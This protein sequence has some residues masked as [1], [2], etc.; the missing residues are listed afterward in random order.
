MKALIRS[1][2]ATLLTAGMASVSALALNPSHY[3][4]KSALSS[5]KWVKVRVSA[6]GVHQ[7]GYDELRQMGFSDPSKVKVCGFGGTYYYKHQFGAETPDDVN[8]TP[9]VH[10]ADG[11]L[12]FYA[13]GEYR[14]V[15]SN[16]PNVTANDTT[17]VHT[18][19][20]QHNV[21]DRYGY[22]FLTDAD[23]DV[24]RDAI[25][26]TGFKGDALTSHLSVQK[27]ERNLANKMQGG[28]AFHDVQM[29]GGSTME[30][31]MTIKN[32]A[33][34]V[35]GQ[36]GSFLA[37]VAVGESTKF[38][39]YS[40]DLQLPDTITLVASTPCY[41]SSLSS[42]DFVYTMANGGRLFDNAKAPIADGQYTFKLNF[43]TAYRLSYA[44][45][46][47]AFLVYPRTNSLDGA[48]GG[49]VMQY[50]E[51]KE[52]TPVVVSGATADTH[53]F[54]ISDAANVYE[55]KGAYDKD[56]LTYT[57]ALP[58]NYMSSSDGSG[59]GRFVA[60]NAADTHPGV[61]LVGEVAN[62][63]IHA[64][65]VPDMMVITTDELLPAARAMAAMRQA[66]DGL[67][68]A[69]YTQQQ[70]FN[71]FTSGTPHLNAYRLAA[72]MFWDRDP[73]RFKYVLLYGKS[74]W[75]P[76]RYELNVPQEMLLTYEVEPYGQQMAYASHHVNLNFATD[77]VVGM[78]ADGFT[79]DE[80]PSTQLDVAVGRLPVKSVSE[81]NELTKKLEKYLQNLP[82]LRSTSRALIITDDGDSNSHLDQGEELALY[83]KGA[84]PSVTSIKAYNSIYPR[85]EYDNPAARAFIRS[86]LIEGVGLF[87]YSGHGRP[88]DLASE[89]L[90][91]Q[92][93]VERTA[94][95]TLPLA[96][97]ST[98]DTYDLDRNT[99]G[100]AES[101]V[102]AP[103]GGSIASVAACRSVYLSLNQYIAM[104]V[105][106][107][108]TETSGETSVG[109][110]YRSAHNR[111]ISSLG[112]SSSA[113]NG[114]LNTLCYN[115]CGDPSMPILMPSQE[116]VVTELNGAEVNAESPVAQ[117]K[118][119][120]YLELKGEIRA[121]GELDASFNGTAEVL[122]YEAPHI[123]PVILVHSGQDLNQNVE[124]DQNL[125]A[126][127]TVEVKD[128]KWQARILVPNNDYV[129]EQNRLVILATQN[130]DD[131]EAEEVAVRA[132]GVFDRLV[133]AGEPENEFAGAG[134]VIESLYIN[135]ADFREGDMVPSEFTL[136]ATV[137]LGEG[138]LNMSSSIGASTSLHLDGTTPVAGVA[139]SMRVLS[140][141]T[142]S[143]AMPMSEIADGRHTLKLS[144]ADNA[145][146]RSE[147]TIAFV[148][149]NGEVVG[150]L[151]V[152]QPV[153][154][155]EAV[156]D[157]EENFA[158]FGADDS[159]VH[160]RLVIV[161]NAG[162][163]VRSVTNP[164]FP[165]TWDLTD[166][167]GKAV[168]DGRYSAWVIADSNNR[169][170]ATPSVTFTVIR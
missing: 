12:L 106:R 33:N 112:N 135:N 86:S 30:V 151:T 84:R 66:A 160:T 126:G 166:T 111:T 89:F 88:T 36:F 141:N 108:Y 168:P 145:G 116:A 11:R 75:D 121:N 79:Y 163:T 83:M 159:P 85:T 46:D 130:A 140:D 150:T 40:V 95:S 43:P 77:N 1:T 97:L 81:G 134:P 165:Y 51:T 124:L 128:G 87:S 62:Q 71:E 133:V 132:D 65:K 99:V 94:Y 114:K 58:R 57:F 19:V 158:D 144:V 68:V 37:E 136:Y 103:N 53:V 9:S 146:N 80:L 15:V 92:A 72:K 164:A 42:S 7:V 142:A 90:W 119:M 154:R 110:I 120:Q 147:R 28:T 131:I 96:M 59:T 143:L 3:V 125:L 122:L 44:A 115:L 157:F 162:T 149:K 8:Q 100:I 109:A 23:V 137:S 64:D 10:T 107:A 13:D 73:E 41:A 74:N 55:L 14:G 67:N 29:K 161:N 78:L 56:A 169:Y 22:Y 70:L 31:P 153:A 26:A 148:V 156:L 155:T 52:G 48:R 20:H 138:G 104:A 93:M 34:G 105:A 18:V 98:C 38:S 17:G 21:Y 24:R 47:R 39:T 69:V 5:G 50:V 4:T 123:S 25:D 102:K 129:G 91:S 118:P 139:H 113:L 32:Y 82:A 61:E 167:A 27:F 76:R 101:M 63:N 117:I 152:E 16:V 170:M 54:D 6:E 2:L 35:A 45:L 60:F 49:L 127:T